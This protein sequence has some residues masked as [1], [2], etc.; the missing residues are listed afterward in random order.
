ML[1]RLLLL[2]LPLALFGVASAQTKPDFS[3]SWASADS[4]EQ[5]S[6][7]ATGDAPFVRG[8]M[9]SGWGSPLT[10]RQDRNSVAIEY[11]HFSTYDMQPPLR[12]VYALDGSDSVN[13]L[14]IGH[15]ESTQHSRAVWREQTLLITTQIEVPGSS[16]RVEVQQALTLES[17]QTLVIETTRS[18]NFGTA[19]SVT[20]TRYVRR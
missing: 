16:M 7:A 5:P 3:G 14:M 11:A 10:I 4:K 8:D 20:R 18:G 13:S 19:P 1:M 17:P 6:I 9:G 2:L 12:L 15:A